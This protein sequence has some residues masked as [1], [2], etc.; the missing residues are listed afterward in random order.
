MIKSFTD[1]LSLSDFDHSAKK[2]PWNRVFLASFLAFMQENSHFSSFLRFDSNRMWFVSNRVW[3]VRSS[4]LSISLE[5][6]WVAMKLIRSLY[7]SYL[8]GRNLENRLGA[9][10]RGFES[11][12]LR[13]SAKR[14]LGW[15][16]VFALWWNKRDSKYNY[17]WAEWYQIKVGYRWT[18]M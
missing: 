6:K 11:H 3:F 7:V 13:Q 18:R 15:V 1:Y 17:W 5:V 9:S 16:S 2:L 4:L 8:C 10:P 12:R 14:I